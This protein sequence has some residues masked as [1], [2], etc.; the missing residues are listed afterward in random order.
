MAEPRV[1]TGATPMRV[2]RGRDGCNYVA[3]ADV[4]T[5]CRDAA[6][7]INADKPDRRALTMLADML[8]PHAHAEEIMPPPPQMPT[9]RC[10]GCGQRVAEYQRMQDGPIVLSAT[11]T[12]YGRWLVIQTSDGYLAVPYDAAKHSRLPWA[13]YREHQCPGWT[14]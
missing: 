8:A 6:G 5:L 11:P 9:R 12:P 1:T 4:V 13:R 2:L 14:R 7:P 10:T 3:V